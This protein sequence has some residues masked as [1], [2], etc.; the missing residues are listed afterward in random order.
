MLAAASMVRSARYTMLKSDTR[1]REDM[2][3]MTP[4]RHVAVEILDQLLGAL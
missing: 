1:N 3:H 4:S 2:M